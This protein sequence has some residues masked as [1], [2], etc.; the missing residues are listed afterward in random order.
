MLIISLVWSTIV[1]VLGLEEGRPWGSFFLQYLWE[2]GLGMIVA[3]K[4]YQS[5]LSEDKP[6]KLM[7]ICTYKWWWLIIGAVGG[8]GLSAFM[9]WNGGVLKLYNDIPSLIGYL[10]VALLIYKIGL[11]VVD[12]FFE[13]TN[14][15][16][17]EL[18]LVHSLVYTVTAYLLASYL[19]VS[20]LLFLQF[21]VAYVLAYT[22][23]FLTKKISVVK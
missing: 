10:S 23:S 19:P 11:K 6:N 12:S 3:E 7:D 17:Y 5:M 15:F 13:W 2:F 16:S 8:M 20:V 1:G 9:A 21:F 14:S 4:V 18:Y 22:F